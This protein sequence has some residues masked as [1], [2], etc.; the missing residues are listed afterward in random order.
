MGKEGFCTI[1][2]ADYAPFAL[3]LYDSIIRFDP[4][5][6][7][8]LFITSGELDDQLKAEMEM[9]ENLLIYREDTFQ[10]NKLALSLKTKYALTNSDAYRWS[11]KPVMMEFLLKKQ[12]ER[13]I[14]LDSDIYF[15]GDYSFLFKK[16]ET[17]SILLSPHNRCSNPRLDLLNFKLNFLEGLYNGGF[18]GASKKGIPALQY[19]A[20]LCL[21]KCEVDRSDGFYDDQ[22]YLD[23]LPTLFE[24]V[25]HINHK[26]CNVANWNQFEC[27]RTKSPDGKILINLQYPIIF[28]HFTKSFFYGVLYS[29]DNI[30]FPYLDE[31]RKA[32]LKYLKKD[33]ITEFV[34]QYKK[35]TNPSRMKKPFWDK[36]LNKK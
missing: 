17:S 36:I 10:N 30:L 31:Y 33:I 18:I 14:Y 23:I 21:F 29:S 8:A 3:A 11:M 16:L 9:R 1:I 13:I 6:I 5:K 7:L 27:K 2:T 15:F 20:N 25:V 4:N 26:G 28:I 32:L 24:G 35:E 12:F 19:W 22:R 34:D